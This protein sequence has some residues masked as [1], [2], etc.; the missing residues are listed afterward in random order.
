M[1]PNP[2]I[3]L[4]RA[5]R[6][7]EVNGFVRVISAGLALS[8]FLFARGATFNADTAAYERPIF[9]LV[10][11]LAP[12]YVWGFWF[13]VAAMLYVL[14]ALTARAFI[15]V[16][17]IISSS[18][19]LGA[20]ISCIVIQ[21]RLSTEALLTDGALGYFVMSGVAIIGLSFAPRQLAVERPII[22]ADDDGNVRELRRS[23]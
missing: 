12:M 9:D 18:I 11:Q 8:M 2:F 20:W 17:A 5:V 22:M 7:S 13:F 19:T 15:Y 14:V 10:R 1:H 23:S 16:M 6:R 21:S 3:A 4:W